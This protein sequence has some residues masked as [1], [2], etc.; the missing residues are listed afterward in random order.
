M[1]RTV[2]KRISNAQMIDPNVMA[3]VAYC[4]AR[5]RYLGFS[6]PEVGPVLSP[7]NLFQCS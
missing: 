7:K 5:R 3:I 2:M 6:T 4:Y 1:L